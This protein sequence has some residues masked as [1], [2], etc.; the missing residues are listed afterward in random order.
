VP[1]LFGFEPWAGN[2]GLDFNRMVTFRAENG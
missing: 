2:G 1:Y